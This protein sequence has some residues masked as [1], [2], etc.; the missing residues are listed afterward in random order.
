MKYKLLTFSLLFQT[1]L[2]SQNLVKNPSFEE[3]KECPWY[4]GMFNNNVFYWSCPNHGSTDFFRACGNTKE[5]FKNYNG[6]QSPLTG[7]AYAGIYCYAIDD[8][9]EYIQ[10]ELIETLTKD[11]VYTISFNLSLA[12]KSSFSIKNIS[13]LFTG[14]R[15]GYKIQNKSILNTPQNINKFSNLTDKFINLEELKTEFS[16]VF[17]DPLEAFYEDKNDWM[18]VTFSYE[19]KGFEKFIT[20]GNFNSNNTT[21][22]NQVLAD[23]EHSFAYYYIDDI[24]VE[25]NKTEY[26]ANTTYVFKNVLFDF[27]KATILETSKVEL[28]ALY[29][30]LKEHPELHIEVYGHTDAV[31]TETRNEELSKQRAE[32]VSNFLVEKG[33]ESHK[34]KWFG[35]GSSKPKVSNDTEANRAINRRVEFKLLKK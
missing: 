6:M 19:A 23:Y 31:G 7:D 20:I 14:E 8:Y 29:D 1:I 16:Q 33:L 34:V 4:I 11:E 13:V 5:T 25:V 27:D 32:A 15:I 10:G 30:Y 28:N 9:R 17:K 21:E 18:K 26:K 3:F 12:E 24:S 35:F 2:F 22:V